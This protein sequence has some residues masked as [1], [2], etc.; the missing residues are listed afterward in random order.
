MSQRK[1]TRLTEVQTA[2]IANRYSKGERFSTLQQEFHCGTA[3]IY[4]ALKTHG[5]PPLTRS[6]A[7]TQYT[8][9]EAAF[10]APLSAEALYWLGFLATDGCVVSNRGNGGGQDQVALTLARVDRGH[11]L[12]F[13][14]FLQS[15][16]PLLDSMN[17]K[18]WVEYPWTM[19][20]VSSQK[21]CDQL[22]GLGITKRKT[23]TLVVTDALASSPDFWRGALDGD[24]TVRWS[25]GKQ[26]YAQLVGASLPFLQQFMSFCEKAGVRTNQFMKTGNTW[27]ASVTGRENVKLLLAITYEKSGPVLARKQVEVNLLREK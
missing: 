27:K 18:N 14:D 25:T 7:G 16:A 20:R 5:V 21:L 9:N 11:V 17:L 3:A 15:N 10:D 22:A 4:S 12:A 6:V 26:P 23:F 1:W 8:K 2:E 24:G 13:R 19:L